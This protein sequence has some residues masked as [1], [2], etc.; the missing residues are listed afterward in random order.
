M[1]LMPLGTTYVCAAPVAANA[2]NV[3]LQAA[4]LPLENDAPVHA[5]QAVAPMELM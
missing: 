3:M 5:L 2:I 4:A 1:L